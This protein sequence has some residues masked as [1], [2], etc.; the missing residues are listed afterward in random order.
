VYIVKK[1]TYSLTEG[2]LFWNIVRYTIPIILTSVLQ[3]L[4]NAADLVVVGQFGADGS[5]AISAVGATG[6]LIN[7]LVGLF[8]GLSL[9]AGVCVAQGVGAQDNTRIHRAVHTALPAAA[10]CGAFLT[11]VGIALAP[12]LLS[13]MG[14]P[15][16]VIDLSVVYMRIYFAGI[17]P[18]LLYNFGASILR[19]AG[20][21]RSPLIILII[22]GILNVLLN[23]FFV[24]VCNMTVSGVATATAIA[25]T[26][27]CVLV[28]RALMKRQDGCKLELKKLKIYPHTL[29]RI[30]Q[31][32]LP[33]GIQGSLFAISNVT[34]QSS[35]NSFGPVVLSGS[36]A[37]SNIEGFVYMS[38]N[39]FQQT[40]MTFVGQNMGAGKIKNI[41]KCLGLCLLCVVTVGVV[42]GG[43]CYL[44]APHLLSIYLKDD[45]QA[46]A[47][48][49][50]RMSYV[51][52]PYFLC[53]MMDVL[54]GTMRGMGA[55]T[56][57]MI[58]TL[59][60][61]CGLRVLWVATIFQQNRTLD[62]LFLCYTVSWSVTVPVLFG[63]F[64]VLWLKM[65]RKQ[66][67]ALSQS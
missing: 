62:C 65:L 13:W 58:V 36:T 35:I 24:L 30:I 37:A 19:S 40:A 57:P 39:A 47:Y 10:I 9:G 43:G 20:D 11:V 7:L 42:L 16:E 61:A 48:G 2:P 5:K 31:I 4:F 56:V 1:Q 28:M 18:T 52:L 22:A 21:S 12:T 59:L 60:G 66:K 46:I 55:S 38:M 45:A 15:D 49:V 25:Q 3:L 32:G 64:M 33:A 41:G 34:I 53:G 26:V 8:M 51:G 6:S 44:A 63:C 67:T 50:L 27:S 29:K 17:I 54:S 23:L 14:T